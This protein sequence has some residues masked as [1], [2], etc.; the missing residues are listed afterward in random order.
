[1]LVPDPTRRADLD[2]IMNHH[3]LR[4]YRHFFE[5]TVEE[6]EEAAVLQKRQEY[7]RKLRARQPDEES[8]HRSSRGERA[9]LC[10]AVVLR[11]CHVR[12]GAREPLP[13]F[14]QSSVIPLFCPCLDGELSRL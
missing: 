14:A 6:C 12:V 1:M 10:T 5:R 9:T 4:T 13:S 3:C 8:S 7:P 11:R 2:T